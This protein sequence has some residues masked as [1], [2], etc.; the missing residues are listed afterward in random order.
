MHQEPTHSHDPHTGTS[1]PPR[2]LTRAHGDDAPLPTGLVF[3]SH[4]EVSSSSDATHLHEDFMACANHGN[5]NFSTFYAQAAQYLPDSVP[6]FLECYQLNHVDNGLLTWLPRT[7]GFFQAANEVIQAPPS[8]VV[9]SEKPVPVSELSSSTSFTILSNSFASTRTANPQTIIIDR[10]S[11]ADGSTY[12]EHKESVTSVTELMPEDAMYEYHPLSLCNTSEDERQESDFITIVKLEH[13]VPRCLPLLDKARMALDKGAQA[14]IFD[15]S[16]DANAAAELRETDALPRPVVLVEAEHAEELMGL[17]NKNEE[18]KVRIEIKVEQ[19]RWPH[20]DM[21][22]LLTI[23]L[24]ILTIVLIFA[25]RYKCKSNR[26]WDSVHQQTMRAINRLETKTYNSQGCSGSQRH[27]AAWG[28]ASS[29]NSS[30][31]CAI[32]LEE[33][34]DGQHLRIISCAHEFHKD[35]V[36][37]WLVQHR[38]CPLCMHNIM[39]TERQPQRSRLQQSPEQSQGFLQPQ[40]YSSPHNHP[41][42]QHAIPFSMRPHYPRGPSG[43]YP[44]LG[45]YSGSSPMDT[46]TLRFLTS[47]PLGP[48]CG[49]RLPAEGPGR[50][51]RIGGNCRTS[52]HHYTPRR[53]CHNYRL[54]CPTQRSASCSRLHHTASG[55]PQTR[56]AP[57]HSRQDEGSCSGGSYHTER[58]GYLADGPASDSSSGPCHG[59]SSDSVLNCTDVSLQGVYGSWSTFRSSLSSDYD[60]FVYFGPGPG[61]GPRRNSLEA[62]AQA[63]PRSLDSVVNKAGCPEEQPQTVF[64]HIH[65]HRHR[66]H[67][68]EEGEHSQG[69]SRG[70]DEEQGAAAAAA[71]AALVLDKDSP[72]GPAKHSPCQCPKPDPT[73]RPSPGQGERHDH[74][75]SSPSGPPVLMSPIPLQL[76]PH[77]CHQGHGHPPAPLGRVGGCVLDGPSVRFHQSL[78]LPDDRSI[79]IHY[80]QGPGFCCSPPELHPALLPVPLILDSGGMEEWPCCAGA[81]V[82]WQKRVQQ[83]RS[84]PQLLGPGTSMDRPPCRLHHGPAADCNTDICLYCQTLHHNQGSEEESGV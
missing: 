38:T 14:V 64:S 28:S 40:H 66:H 23:I 71:P 80:G 69:P 62:G 6:T 11:N 44:S 84:E 51:H 56:G 15:V 7:H 41:F 75:P 2:H 35:C 43:P 77:C 70:S 21:G 33:F 45:H 82:V 25:F 3:P 55:T 34:Q 8:R 63:R 65:Y 10:S 24:A 49:Y 50:P 27:R 29:S 61:R 73:D 53:S 42:P 19:S 32:C 83:A 4:A 20:Y 36:D 76:Q 58:S 5:P 39:G 26:T 78:D 37:P 57:A 48:G 18:A 31:V 22:I 68:Y 17:V 72:V 59:S 1:V 30:P 74:D 67:H 79:H 47:R 60:P 9:S 12:S 54:S 13:R 16:D 52:T 46:Q 81:H